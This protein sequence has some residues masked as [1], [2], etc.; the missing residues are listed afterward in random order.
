[1]KDFKDLRRG[2]LVKSKSSGVVYIVSS[3]YGGRVTAV[4]TADLTNPSE[5]EHIKL[6]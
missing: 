2:D 1:M 3:N 5:W 6:K 4:K